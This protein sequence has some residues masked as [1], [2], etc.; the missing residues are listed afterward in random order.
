SGDLYAQISYNKEVILAVKIEDNINITID[1]ASNDQI[2]TIT[3]KDGTGKVLETKTVETDNKKRIENRVQITD[4]EILMIHANCQT[5]RC[6]YMKI[7]KNIPTPIICTNGI[8]VE[9]IYDDVYDYIHI[10]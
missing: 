6:M 5:K 8:I 3:A 4:K 9:L 2:L 10:L 1:I 7:T